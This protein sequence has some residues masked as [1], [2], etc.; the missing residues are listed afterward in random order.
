M[1]EIFEMTTAMMN[2]WTVLSLQ[3]A[4]DS[5]SNVAALVSAG[6]IFHMSTHSSYEKWKDWPRVIPPDTV[7]PSRSDGEFTFFLKQLRVRQ[8]LPNSK[9]GREPMEAVW[10]S[11]VL[12]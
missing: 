11:Q 1:F 10:P 8:L 12:F 2:P 7:E 5:H 4:S 9:Q 6:L 3:S